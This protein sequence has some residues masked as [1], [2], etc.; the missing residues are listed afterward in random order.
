MT[1]CVKRIL[2]LSLSRTTYHLRVIYKG[3]GPTH[4][5]S[6]Q[7]ACPTP[8]SRGES[9]ERDPVGSRVSVTRG[10]DVTRV[11]RRDWTRAPLPTSSVAL[12]DT[13]HE[14]LQSVKKDPLPVEEVG[15]HVMERPR[16]VGQTRRR[17]PPVTHVV[18]R[19]NLFWVPSPPHS[20]PFPIFSFRPSRSG[21]WSGR[22]G[23]RVD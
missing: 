1:G 9:V 4:S 19:R 20:G 21:V 15:V 5:S 10:N 7:I 17:T 12:D 11:D 6:L 13:R 2:L 23:R 18:E 14:E 8:G 22:T 16:R 3:K